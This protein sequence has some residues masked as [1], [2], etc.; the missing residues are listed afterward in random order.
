VRDPR[1]RKRFTCTEHP[2]KGKF[3]H[4]VY[5]CMAVYGGY[6]LVLLKLKTGRTHQI[7]VHMKH[8]GC[9]ILGDPI[10]GKHDGLFDSATMMLHAKTLGVRL[11]G[12][13]DFSVF[14]APLPPR[15]KKVIRKLRETWPRRK[16]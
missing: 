12:S 15:F 13:K 16:P 6:S 11:P 2:Q 4:T 14:E 10:Y 5:R 7:R 1:N 9:P 3:A 8:L